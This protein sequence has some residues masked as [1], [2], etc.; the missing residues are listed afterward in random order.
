GD[1]EVLT[2]TRQG[3]G[4]KAT[5]YSFD[6][7]D[8]ESHVRIAMDRWKMDEGRTSYV[9]DWHSHPSG[10]ASPSGK[11]R[12]AWSILEAHSNGPII[13]MILGETKRVR[14]FRCAKSFGLVRVREC[15]LVGEDDTHFRYAPKGSEA[16]D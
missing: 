1:I 3:P 13:G 11:D 7:N 8:D 16:S 5:P 10:D 12:K 14:V 15:F 2:A 9:G 6:R 4:D